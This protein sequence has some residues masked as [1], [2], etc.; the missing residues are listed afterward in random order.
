MAKLSPDEWQAISPHLD[1]A[2]EMTGDERLIWLSSLQTENPALAYQ[3]EI[4]LREHRVLSDKGFLEV[5]ALELPGGPGLVGHTLGVY[6]LVTQIGHGGMGTVWLAER[7]DGRFERRVAVKVLNFAL[8]G[9]GGEERFKREGRILGRLTHPHIAELIDAGVSLAGQPFLVLEYVEGDHIDRYCDHNGLDVRARVRLFI[10]A[11]SAVAQAH[12]NHIVHRDL[13]P[14]NILVRTDG[15]AKL[16]DFGIAKL[17][18]CDGQSG[19]GPPTLEGGRAMTPEYAAPEQLKGEPVTAA[20]DVYASG[21]L[22]YVLLTGH[23]PTGGAPRTPA[24]LVKAILDTEPARPSDIVAPTQANQETSATNARRRGTTPDKLMR[25][26]RGDLDTIVAKALK[27]NPQERYLSINAFAD[28]LQRYL[29]YEP[30]SARPDTTTY[31]TGKFIRRHRSTVVAALLVT[32]ALISTTIFTWFFPRRTEPLP[33]FKQRK[34]TANA[35]DSPVLNAAISPDG[36]YLGYGDQ[37]GI[38]LQL[39]ATSGVQSLTLPADIQPEKDS[40]AFGSW[41]PDSTGFLA[42]ASVPGKP[43]TVWSIPI[44]GGEAQKLAEVEDMFGGGSVSPDGSNIAY[45][46]LRSGDGAREIWVIGSHGDSPHKILTA[47]NQATISGIAWSPTG[48]RLAY[49]YRRAKGDRTEILVQSCDLS[50]A[51]ITTILLDNHLT[52]FT[53]TLSGRFIYSRNSEVGSAESDNLWELKV[54]GKNGT[55]QGKAH[56]LTDWSGFSVYSF[57]ATGDGKHLAFLRRNDHASVFVGDLTGNERHLVNSRRLTLDD[58]YNILLAWTPDSREV[59]FSSQRATNRL[60]YRQALDPGSAPQLITPAGDTNFFVARLSPD[61]ASI[62]LE[63][64]PIA[65]HKMGLYRVDLEGGIPHLLFNTDGFV[66]FWC[67]NRAANLCVF[68][69]PSVGKNELV[70]VAFDPLGGPGK[71]LVRI[72]LE[73]GSSAD[74]GFD[75][76]W[77][78]S[79]DGS[80]IGIVRRHGHQIRLVP[81]GGGQT[82]TITVKGYPDLQ[83]LNWANDSQ[84]MFVSSVEPGA[85]A[86]LHVGLNGDA[87]PVWQQPQPNLTWGFPSPDGHHLAILGVSSEANVWMISNF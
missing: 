20:T 82:R 81:L 63:G 15:Q 28:D 16:L 80:R 41:F 26:L 34:L 7:N 50:G 21:V 43:S 40:W 32:L 68:G 74:I 52:A 33:Q 19:E 35:Q 87:Q 17:L 6:T 72:P 10:D 44:L 65:S 9:K 77:R 66:M 24:G 84:S 42:S 85:A 59:I 71:E 73:A 46:R 36:K 69:K 51:G 64:A 62:L 29:R 13:K 70:V 37:Q 5:S 55:P 38:H 86:L 39:V 56:Q 67:T 12:A 54:D 76:S 53:W 22:L 47:E 30:T 78:L 1:Q 8:M 4:L 3:L 79:P 2:L 27:K 60:I 48:N 25:L 83:D 31:R 58:N 75:Y 45:E 14:S 11:L 49:R 23:H 57:S 18:E 61:G